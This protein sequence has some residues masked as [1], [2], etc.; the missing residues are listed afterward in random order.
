MKKIT[1]QKIYYFEGKNQLQEK[2]KGERSA[3]NPP[4]LKALLRQQGILVTK[5]Q[6]R[7]KWALFARRINNVDITQF[8]RQFAT[9]LTAGIAIIQALEILLRGQHKP[10]MQNLIAR[11][12]THIENGFSVAAALRLFPEHFNA[13]YCNL[14]AVGEHSGA[15][16]HLFDRVALY[17]EKMQ[18]LK[19]RVRKALFYPITIIAIAIVVTI[20]MLVWVVPQ[21]SILFAGFN[22]TLPTATLVVIK[23]SALVQRYGWIVAIVLIGI[24]IILWWLLLHSI[25][26]VNVIDRWLIKMPI[27]GAILTKAIIARFARTLAITVAAG[28]PLADS[29]MIVS[30]VMGNQ[31][32]T[33]AV[34]RIR[35]ELIKGQNLQQSLRATQLFPSMVVQMIAIGEESGTLDV[36][37][38]KVAIMFEQ[39]L[40]R[41]V[42]SLSQLLEP[43]IMI[44]LGI[45]IGGLVIAMYLPIFKL[46]S[47][48]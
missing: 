21:F 20:A 33:R 12:K 36:M 15:L 3:E 26:A 6:R 43:L 1:K 46:G 32:Y 23:L 7:F 17:K 8:S 13:L 39:D 29:L 22:A 35:E 37:L 41:A 5:I 4:Q 18:L 11:L 14:I 31:V 27:Y 45:V 24:I 48:V 42:D 30:G 44:I 19:Q 10:R 28:L 16:D 40:D 38:N 47:V 9:L 25:R 34:L 2:V